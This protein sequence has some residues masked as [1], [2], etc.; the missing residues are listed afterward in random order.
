MVQVEGDERAVLLG[1]AGKLKAELAGLGRKR[2]D[3]TRQVKNANTLFAKQTL[4]VEILNRKGT[5]DLACA[6]VLYTRAAGTVARVCDVELMAVAPRTTLLNL[7]TLKGHTTAEKVVLD[8]LG[9]RAILNE[10]GQN[11]GRKTEVGRDRG[12]VG[13][14]TRDLHTEGLGSVNRLTV[15]RADTHTHTGGNNK[16][17]LVI[18]SEL[19]YKYSFNQIEYWEAAV[20]PPLPV[21]LVWKNWPRGASMRS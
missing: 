3:K 8:H 1:S 15:G 5:A 6:V 2:T 20:S 12:Y 17:V 11:M 18:F 19:H 13:L 9:D 16:S 7:G 10:S 4:K 14:G 21:Q